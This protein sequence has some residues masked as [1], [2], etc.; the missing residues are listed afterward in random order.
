MNR[1]LIFAFL[2]FSNSTHSGHLEN[3]S[4]TT[5]YQYFFEHPADK[6][7]TIPIFLD[8][9]ERNASLRNKVRLHAGAENNNERVLIKFSLEIMD[10]ALVPQVEEY[11]GK[12][13]LR[14]GA[15]RSSV[16][17]VQYANAYDV[18]LQLQKIFGLVEEKYSPKGKIVGAVDYKKEIRIVANP[19]MN[20]VLL[21]G[22]YHKVLKAEKLIREMDTRTP[23]VLVEVLITEV[24]LNNDYDLGIEWNSKGNG[25]G[26]GGVENEAKVDFGTINKGSDSQADFNLQNLQGLKFSIL[27]QGNFEF[28]L[29]SVEQLNSIKVISRPK[30]LTA[31]NRPAEFKATQ[32]NPILKSTNADGVVE[33]TVEYIDIGVTLQVTPRINRDNYIS[34]GIRQTIQEILG[35]DRNA[36][37]SPVFSERMVNSDILVKDNHTLVLG[38]I[39]S[40]S[41]S[42]RDSRIPILSKIPFI[43]HWFRRK[44]RDSTNTEMLIFLTP[45]IIRDYNTADDF[46]KLQADEHR[47][48]ES[49][50][51]FMDRN[52]VFSDQSGD[53]ISMIGTVAHVNTNNSTVLINA[54]DDDRIELGESYQVVRIRKELIDKITHQLM[55]HDYETIGHINILG[56]Q[57]EG[58]FFAKVQDPT[59]PGDILV[60]D[61]IRKS[62]STFFL[63]KGETKITKVYA[64]TRIQNPKDPIASVEVRFDGINIHDEPLEE[65]TL[66]DG[67]FTKD[68]QFFNPQTNEILHA[69]IIDQHK[70]KL[71]DSH[72]TKG[73]PDPPVRYTFRA[74]LKEPIPP[75]KPFSILYRTELPKHWLKMMQRR[76]KF[77]LNSSNNIDSIYDLEYPIGF[78]I[79]KT[80]P[81][82]VHTFER[83]GYT[84]MRYFKPKEKFQMKVE[85]Y[86]NEN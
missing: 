44:V 15:I 57:S 71:G 18:A 27:N 64:R 67:V 22:L 32:R 43:K 79:Q 85:H 47:S 16:V 78:P 35:F 20:S 86:Y 34:L 45:H 36:L 74:D 31:N 59:N 72:K 49:I 70:M 13:D 82:P 24:T 26:G 3:F 56:K 52:K 48:Q 39:I 75:G 63:S 40:S 83:D 38:G 53:G 33:S 62:S 80:E 11:L 51:S 30:I 29:N 41:E 21:D 25:P 58:L 7:E 60:G 69:E 61:R 1:I 66:S 77:I 8:L 73:D 37:N 81:E 50:I 9:I 68:T 5:L 46:T 84:V 12:L 55:G 65:F 19:S 4:G 23:Q 2:L 28:F 17:Q 14:M 10:P 6:K 54:V 76:K 42:R